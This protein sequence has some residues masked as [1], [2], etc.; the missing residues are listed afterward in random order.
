MKKITITWVHLVAIAILILLTAAGV[1]LLSPTKGTIVVQN[2]TDKTVKV[3]EIKVCGQRFEILNLKAISFSS[4]QYEVNVDS[5]YDVDV[6]FE[7]NKKI[8]SSGGYVTSGFDYVDHI[9]VNDGG[10]TIETIGV[11]SP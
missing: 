10:I 11:F 3:V 8:S 1:S 6:T 5:H 4:L 2:D 7:D 9:T